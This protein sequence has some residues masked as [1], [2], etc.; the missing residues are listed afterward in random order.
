[1]SRKYNGNAMNEVFT[2]EQLNVGKVLILAAGH[3]LKLSEI[4][5][6][7]RATKVRKLKWSDKNDDIDTFILLTMYKT[8]S[9]LG[10]EDLVDGDVYRVNGVDAVS[11]MLVLRTGGTCTSVNLDATKIKKLHNACLTKQCIDKARREMLSALKSHNDLA[12][13]LTKQK[14]KNSITKKTNS[15][16]KLAKGYADDELELTIGSIKEVMA[17]TW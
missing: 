13:M 7:T 6:L 12:V 15:L 4:K 8:I 1:M 14:M 17:N 2:D 10:N 11:V 3:K 9:A 5:R 16:E